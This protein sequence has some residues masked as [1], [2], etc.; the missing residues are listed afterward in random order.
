MGEAAA[1]AERRAR[2]FVALHER[3][4]A[5]VHDHAGRAQHAGA[6]GVER[7][8][9]QHLGDAGRVGAVDDDHVD[10]GVGRLRHVGDAVAD[11][12]AGAGVVPRVASERRQVGAGETNDL[13][14]DLDHHRALNGAML[15][16]AA[17]HAAIAGADDQHPSRFAMR[18]QRYV[19]DHLLVDEL[20]SLGYLHRAVEHHH[21]PMRGAVKDHDVLKGAAHAGEFAHDA[22][23]LAPVGIERF[24]NPTCHRESLRELVKRKAKGFAYETPLGSEAPDLHRWDPLCGLS[25]L[26]RPIKHSCRRHCPRRAAQVAN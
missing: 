4:A 26:A 10:A 3:H 18:Q 5:L 2:Q 17:Q 6:L 13:A 20:V 16:H 9:E 8:A 15:Q 1:P 14:V 21:A 12:D 24:A 11:D 22:E 19:R 23:A 25:C 7:L